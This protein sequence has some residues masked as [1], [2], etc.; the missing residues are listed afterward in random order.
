MAEPEEPNLAADG[1]RDSMQA[2]TEGQV[3]CRA[4]FNTTRADKVFISGMREIL[5]GFQCVLS[6]RQ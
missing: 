4:T 1:Q 3:L 5:I 2:P 6:V